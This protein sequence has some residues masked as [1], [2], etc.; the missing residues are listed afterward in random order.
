MGGVVCNADWKKKVNWKRLLVIQ[1]FEDRE[2]EDNKCWQESGERGVLAHCLCLCEFAQPLRK[3]A[4]RSL[5][6][7]NLALPKGPAMPRLRIYLKEAK[8]VSE[9][10][11]CAPKFTPALFMITKPPER[12]E[13]PS[14]DKSMR[15][16][17]CLCSQRSVTLP[18]TKKEALPSATLWVNLKALCQLK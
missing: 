11:I 16:T 6:I 8:S 10:N 17:W 9:R 7:L 15:K 12:P 5:R 13:C 1:F 2:T 14:A 18:Q 3:R 4:R